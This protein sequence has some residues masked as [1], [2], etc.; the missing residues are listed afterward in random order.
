[1]PVLTQGDLRIECAVLITDIQTFHM[2]IRQNRHAVC[3]V[4]GTMPGAE[5]GEAILQPLAGTRV[6]AG[7][8]DRLLFAGMLQDIQVSHEG[9]HYRVSLTG[10]S[11]TGMLDH[12][13]KDRSFQ[14]VSMT[15]REV[16]ERVLADTPGAGL[17][18]H[19]EDQAIQ[20]PLYQT[21][22]TD[23]V[24]LKR[25]AGRLHTVLVPSVYAAAPC[26]HCGAP[27][28][29]THRE[30]DD[31][32][33]ER[34]WRD[35]QRRGTRRRVRTGRNWDPGDRADWDGYRYTVTDKECR[36]EKGLLQ[37]RYTLESAGAF[38]S[39]P[40]EHPYQAG[41]MLPASV[42]DVRDEQVKVGFDMDRQQPAEGAYWYPWQPDMGNLAYCMPEKGERVYIHISGAA[43]GGDRAV[44]GVRRNGAGNPGLQPSHRYFTTKDRKRLYMDPDAVGFRDLRQEKPLELRL[45]DASGADVA[46]HRSI[47]VSARG[48]IGL[49]GGSILFQ[50]PKE[51]S[52]VKRA[53]SPTVI[54]MCNGFDTIGGSDR[55]LT[56][57]GGGD[58]FPVFHQR[59][60]RA[61]A[62]RIFAD[63]S[64]AGKSVIG[65]TPVGALADSLA[66]QLEGCQVKRIGRGGVSI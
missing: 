11:A 60:G 5:G 14:D 9:A 62:E 8:G 31:V 59:D 32:V 46:S 39:E 2:E 28:G 22:E 7:A 38:A 10:V 53:A 47:T 41:M 44:C 49:K 63:R 20:S 43:G 37:Y 26:F 23:W 52:L 24:F 66:R 56:E 48:T 36:L 27:E 33:C 6:T 34:I 1:M 51:I 16:M 40:Y 64:A 15:C 58:D 19:G 42:L 13:K 35:R 25:L 30:A 4:E 65:S 61:E 57:G 3:R 18:F 54:N 17:L 12:A 50:A 55:V 29:A 45:S 21:G